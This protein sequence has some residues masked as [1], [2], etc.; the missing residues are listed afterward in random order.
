M[1]KLV[2]LATCRKTVRENR[3]DK[4]ISDKVLTADSNQKNRSR[5]VISLSTPQSLSTIHNPACPHPC[6]YPQPCLFED[7][8]KEIKKKENENLI[9]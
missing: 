4:I 6:H 5:A 2:F 9:Y 3:L 1:I 7:A 8:K